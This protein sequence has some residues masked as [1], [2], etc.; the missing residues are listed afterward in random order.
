MNH[1]L[2][3][4]LLS[5]C[6][7]ICIG[8][9]PLASHESLPKK[10]VLL[11]IADDLSATA[12]GCYGN[13]ICKTPNIDRLAGRGML[14]EN[15]YCQFPV[16]GPSRAAL[17]SGM[18]CPTIGIMGNG[19]SSQFTK[20]M[21]ERPT[22]SQFFKN[23]GWYSARVSKIYHMRV[24]G[25]ITAGVD[26]PDHLASWSARFN[27]QGPE[28]MSEGRH[29]HLTNEKLKR[30][31]DQHYSLGFGGAFYTVRTSSSDGKFQPDKLAADKAI[32][33]LQQKRESPF[34]LAVG[35]VRP[36]VP[37]VAPGSYFKE[38]KLSKMLLP[39]TFANDVDDI[40]LAG[41]SKNSVKIGLNSETKKQKVLQ[42]YYASVSFMDY[43]VGRIL[44]QLENLGLSKNT[45]VIF[46][47]DHG[48]HLGEHGFWQKMSLHE[49]SARIPLIVSA[50]G[51]PQ[52]KRSSA[53]VEAIDLYPT[54]VELNQ[55][56]VPSHCQGKS[57]RP[58][59]EDPQQSIREAAYCTT[60]KGNLVR[61][62]RFALIRY[63]DESEEFY[64]MK[65]DPQQF[66][67]ISGL[68]KMASE[69]LRHR[70]L[71]REHLLDQK[72]SGQ[73]KKTGK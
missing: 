59:L 7:V 43:Q 25:D 13:K 46:K 61:T 14:F 48:Y 67:N 21:G 12:L 42:A 53:L 3:R 36:H 8:N 9:W 30:I 24:P 23:Q 55:C 11:I 17:M 50:P 15:A 40:P 70:K 65:D 22:M 10:N 41:I 29:E 49:E 57:L 54:L 27:C 38:Y 20:N 66:K 62:D 63:Q 1:L 32:D 33:L 5:S 72:K 35:F 28:W 68:K 26:G 47:S 60:S 6:L 16:C 31:P 64:D 45:V 18:Y 39:E 44:S 2:I 73:P 4:C 71:I 56:K 37:L 69:V 34:F 51:F 19:G 58:I 52:G